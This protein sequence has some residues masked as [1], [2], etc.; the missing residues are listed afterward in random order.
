[1]NLSLGPLNPSTQTT[2]VEKLLDLF[3]TQTSESIVE[4]DYN[5]KIKSYF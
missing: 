1:M 2:T 4:I 5:V 3:F